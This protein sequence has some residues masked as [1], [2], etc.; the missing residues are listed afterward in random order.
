MLGFRQG[1]TSRQVVEYAAILVDL[2]QAA[3]SRVLLAG[4][5]K[6]RKYALGAMFWWIKEVTQLEGNAPR[7]AEAAL[8][9]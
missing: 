4:K 8:G 9:R 1:V 5:G 7:G 6:K 3:S 2:V